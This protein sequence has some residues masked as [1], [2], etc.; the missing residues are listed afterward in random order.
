MKETNGVDRAQESRRWA[1]DNGAAAK[2][3]PRTVGWN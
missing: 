3:G 2:R 1:C